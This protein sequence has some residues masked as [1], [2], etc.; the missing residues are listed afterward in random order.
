MVTLCA[1]VAQGARWETRLTC[2]WSDA[3]PPTCD[4]MCDWSDPGDMTCHSLVVSGY[5]CYRLARV[6]V[7]LICDWL[8]PCG[9]DIL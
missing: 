4:L 2:N 9:P 7:D 8:G 3:G 5:V 6:Q 1:S